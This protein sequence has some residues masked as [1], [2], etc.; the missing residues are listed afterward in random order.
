MTLRILDTVHVSLFL[1]GHPKAIARLNEAGLNW[2][3]T[4]ITVQEIFNG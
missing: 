3:I 2:A 4:V 1:G